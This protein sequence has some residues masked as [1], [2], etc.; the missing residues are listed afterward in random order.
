M[1]ND[2]RRLNIRVSDDTHY[3]L[4]VDAARH[5]RSMQQHVDALLSAHAQK[6]AAEFGGKRLDQPQS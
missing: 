3:W 4:N 6:V 1:P 2:I 5:N